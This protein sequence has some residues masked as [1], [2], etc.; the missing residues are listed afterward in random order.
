MVN[1]FELQRNVHA[2]D[3]KDIGRTV[4]LGSE[5]QNII[6]ELQ[7]EQLMQ[8]K[9]ATGENIAPSYYSNAYADMKQGKNSRPD[10]ATP[11]LKQTGDFHRGIYFNTDTMNLASSDAKTPSLIEKYGEHTLGLNE[12]SLENYRPYFNQKTIEEFVAQLNGE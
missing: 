3:L 8:G 1:L 9:D 5:S 7:K 2:I 10:W 6:V 12:D 4:L 11:D